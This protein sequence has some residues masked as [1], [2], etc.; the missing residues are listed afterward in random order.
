M[1]S[2]NSYD[3]FT[4]ELYIRM[5]IDTSILIKTH[6]NILILTIINLSLRRFIIFNP[7]NDNQRP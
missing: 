3:N 2:I 7:P 5:K 4:S 6:V 1:D